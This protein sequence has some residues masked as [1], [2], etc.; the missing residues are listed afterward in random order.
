MPRIAQTKLI[1]SWYKGEIVLPDLQ[2][3]YWEAQL[4]VVN[5]W[6][7]ELETELAWHLD[8]KL[9]HPKG[10][11]AALYDQR[12]SAGLT[13]PTGTTVTIW[14]KVLAKLDWKDKLTRLTPLW[15]MQVL[16]TLRNQYGFAKLDLLGISRVEDLWEGENITPWRSLRRSMS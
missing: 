12:G 9:L 16:G 8:R 6:A 1:K 13:G 2:S 7:F 15:D 5:K 10:Y 4:T 3:Y 14:H 11:L